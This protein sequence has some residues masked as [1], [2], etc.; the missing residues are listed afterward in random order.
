MRKRRFTAE[1][2]RHR[3]DDE[4]ER[5]KEL[6][7]IGV[8]AGG[9]HAVGTILRGLQ[10]DFPVPIA[11]VQH[12]AKESTAL[13][14]VLQECT[15]LRVCEI[16]DKLLLE[17]GQ[18]YIA[19]PDYHVLL[20]DGHFSLSV[21]APVTYSRPS[22][23]VLFESAADQFGRGVI[24]VVLTGANHDGA[25][26]LKHIVERGGH[27]LIQDP[28]S[29]EVAVMPRAA[30]AAVPTATVAPLNELAGELNALVAAGRG[31]AT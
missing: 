24:G 17:A 12:R 22:I 18:V 13:A 23:D 9:L 19:P 1:S 30:L 26:G 25:R 4:D 11:V 28:D 7:V 16:E 2:D 29:A 14:S 10:A 6:V 27:A 15:P 31:G 20:N 21:D 8:S 5:N 3:R